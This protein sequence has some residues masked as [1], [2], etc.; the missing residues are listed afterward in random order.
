MHV[1]E[2]AAH[3]NSQ[4]TSVKLLRNSS[5]RSA[6][7]DLTI[8]RIILLLTLVTFYPLH[9]LMLPLVRLRRNRRH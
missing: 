1:S 8:M 4:V 2:C 3:E 9:I 5:N 7:P 6:L